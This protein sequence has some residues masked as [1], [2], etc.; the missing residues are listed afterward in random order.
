MHLLEKP[1]EGPY[2]YLY[3]EKKERKEEEEKVQLPAGIELV[4]F[5]NGE[6]ALPLC[7]NRGPLQ[8]C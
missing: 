3:D 5:G 4:T 8:A 6:C 1:D 2:P 7:Y